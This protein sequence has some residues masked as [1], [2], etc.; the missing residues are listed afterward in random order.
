MRAC[1]SH[2]GSTA[3]TSSVPRGGG[4]VIRVIRGQ[5]T[6]VELRFLRS[7]VCKIRCLRIF[8]R[9]FLCTLLSLSPAHQLEPLCYDE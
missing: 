2:S 8:L 4:L 3:W 6:S 7:S 1:R 5:R 9:I